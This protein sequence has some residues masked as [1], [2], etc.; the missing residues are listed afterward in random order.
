MVAA[1]HFGGAG[2]NAGMLAAGAI[3]IAVAAVALRRRIDKKEEYTTHADS[4]HKE[5][6]Q[7]LVDILPVGVTIVGQ[8][9]Q[10]LYANEALEN[11]ALLTQDELK[12]GKHIQRHYLRPDLTQRPPEEFATTIAKKSGKPVHNVET[13]ITLED[14][15]V[16][17]TN[18]S[19]A[20][21]PAGG[22]VTVSMDITERKRFEDEIR[23]L[24][25]NLEKRVE[26]RSRELLDALELNRTMLDASAVGII[27]FEGGGTCVFANP[28]AERIVGGTHEQ[29]SRL[30]FHKMESL[31]EYGL[32]DK[33]LEALETG[34][35][36]S[37]EWYVTT[38]FGRRAWLHVDVVR[39]SRAGTPHLLFMIQDVSAQKEAEREMIRA[40]EA[41]ESASQ[42]KSRFLSLMSHELRTPMNAVLGFTQVLRDEPLPPAQREYVERIHSAGGHLLSLLSDILDLSGVETGRL[43]VKAGPVS[44]IEAVN[45]TCEIMS[46]TLQKKRLDIRRAMDASIVVYADPLR[47]RQILTHLITAAA[48]RADVGSSIEI[49]TDA[50]DAH[51]IRL[52]ISLPGAPRVEVERKPEQLGI[53]LTLSWKLAAAMRGFLSVLGGDSEPLFQLTLE[54]SRNLVGTPV[55]GKS[56][57]S[58]LAGRGLIKVL[59]VEDNDVNAMVVKAMF[60][61]EG[62][63]LLLVAENAA[64]GI[65]LAVDHHPDVIL[66]DLNLPDASGYDVLQKLRA[67]PATSTIP[68]IAVTA[69]AMP[70]QVERGRHS[71]FSSYITK[72]FKKNDLF[73]AISE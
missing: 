57:G 8:N 33:A 64:Q 30:D 15:R 10:V 43:E 49:S 42:A 2:E 5:T 23:S 53:G 39:F 55:D 34:V 20:P 28:A 69:D 50:P 47:L 60:R 14:G 25:A 44:L 31:R 67:N 56:G 36:R 38:T 29:I 6:L 1:V 40:K 27:A 51:F 3:A 7:S 52:S 62:G 45:N 46:S 4:S 24:N 71:G 9:G 73:L 63:V 65:G 12:Q 35:M 61:K 13:G 11:L 17:W 19:A 22:V 54:R 59:Y 37:G 58:P 70:D 16:I 66:L 72:P 68:V 18:A 32:Y 26:E 21:L 41:A 48:A